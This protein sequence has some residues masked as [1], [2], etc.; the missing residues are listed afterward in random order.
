MLGKLANV[1][2]GPML[3]DINWSPGANLLK[4][5]DTV[6]IHLILVQTSD[7]FFTLLDLHIIR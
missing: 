3:L 6:Q 4:G 7:F 5:N 1:D 2:I